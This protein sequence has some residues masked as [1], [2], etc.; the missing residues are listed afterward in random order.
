MLDSRLARLD[1]RE[2]QRTGRNRWLLPTQEVAGL[3]G[4]WHKMAVLLPLR[5][6]GCERSEASVGSS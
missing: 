6:H 5:R 2:P 3:H 4:K 1:G